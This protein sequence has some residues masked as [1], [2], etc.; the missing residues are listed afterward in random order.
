MGQKGPL[1]VIR[2]QAQVSEEKLEENKKSHF[3]FQLLL[4]GTHFTKYI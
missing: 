3:E 2:F 4:L 1:T